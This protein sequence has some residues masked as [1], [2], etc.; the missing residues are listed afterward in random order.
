M[1]INFS[2]MKTFKEFIDSSMVGNARDRVSKLVASS[3][4][5][6]GFGVLGDIAYRIVYGLPVVAKEL[7]NVFVKS[8]LIG[9]LVSSFVMALTD[10]LY[11]L[12]SK[13]DKLIMDYNA[14]GDPIKRDE[15]RDK[16]LKIDQERKEKEEKLRKEILEANKKYKKMLPKDKEKIDKEV[17]AKLVKK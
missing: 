9:A 7:P 6:G 16:I 17:E 4:F 8:V 3:I 2:I 14:T 1:Q 11:M 15:I 10:T 13:R 5:S 12:S